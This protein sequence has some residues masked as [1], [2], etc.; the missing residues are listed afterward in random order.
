MGVGCCEWATTLFRFI[1]FRAFRG[2]SEGVPIW[3]RRLAAFRFVR[4]CSGLFGDDPACLAAPGARGWMTCGAVGIDRT[5][6]LLR[7]W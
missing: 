2:D 6:V 5:S 1:L 7:V 4:I 3:S